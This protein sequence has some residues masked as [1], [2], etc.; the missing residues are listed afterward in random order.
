MF[1]A[2]VT[3]I[4]I[5]N[6]ET[7][8]TYFV[9]NMVNKVNLYKG[10]HSISCL[11]IYDCFEVKSP[12]IPRVS[13]TIH[14]V[15]PLFHWAHFSCTWYRNSKLSCKYYGFVFLIKIMSYQYLVNKVDKKFVCLDFEPLGTLSYWTIPLISF[16]LHESLHK[17]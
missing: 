15:N 6:S 9:L 1:W 10:K 12:Q 13:K 11:L 8:L 2:S 16:D 5:Q 7:L 4:I 17:G 3:W 14:L